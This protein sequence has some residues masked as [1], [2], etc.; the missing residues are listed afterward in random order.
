[1]L[2]ERIE[3]LVDLVAT[4][5]QVAVGERTGVG[6]EASEDLS[7]FVEEVLF[8]GEDLVQGNVSGHSSM[9]SS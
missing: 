3:F 1:M 8:P 2:E 6:D 7:G 4:G 5:F 9:S